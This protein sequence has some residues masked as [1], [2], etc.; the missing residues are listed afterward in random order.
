MVMLLMHCAG[1]V[2]TSTAHWES[3]LRALET[4][5]SLRLHG[6]EAIEIFIIS[7]SHRGVR[8]HHQLGH[9]PLAS[10]PPEALHRPAPTLYVRLV[11]HDGTLTEPC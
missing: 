11:T 8:L 4:M 6:G 7:S 5:Q 3:L 9:P 2:L 10:L 1:I